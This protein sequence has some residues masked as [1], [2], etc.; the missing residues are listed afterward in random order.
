MSSISSSKN[1]LS[2]TRAYESTDSEKY[3]TELGVNTNQGIE[4]KQPFSLFKNQARSRSFQHLDENL[5]YRPNSTSKAKQKVIQAPELI[6]QF[7]DLIDLKAK[8]LNLSFELRANEVVI[9]SLLG[10]ESAIEQFE[11]FLKELK[12]K[13]KSKKNFA[14]SRKQE[15]DLKPLIS[16]T[17]S[18]HHS[19]WAKLDQIKTKIEQ[20]G[21]TYDV[22]DEKISVSGPQ[23]SVLE[24]VTWIYEFTL[25]YLEDQNNSKL[26]PSENDICES[27]ISASPFHRMQREAIENKAKELQLTCD[28]AYDLI[29]VSGRCYDV[30]E[31][32]SYL[33]EVEA[34]CKKL[35]YPKFWDFKDFDHYSEIIVENSSEEFAM[36]ADLFYKTMQDFNI[37]KLVRIQNKYLMEN[38]I[39]MIQKRKE[40]YPDHEANRK[41]LFHGTRHSS[42]RLI[43]QSS[44]TGFD[45]QFA[46]TGAYGR[47]LYFAVNADYSHNGFCHEIA[48]NK[49]QMLLTDVFIGKSFKS[50]PNGT[51]RKAPE[52]YDSVETEE[53]FYVIYNNFH[54]Y[55]LYLIEYESKF[56]ETQDD[57]D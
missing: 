52:G 13:K 43:Y 45:L 21:L 26:Q 31:F 56:P 34:T 20:L 33:H 44:D 2:I 25:S 8:D 18:F 23:E 38:Y 30:K 48:E 11:E 32:K 27:E 49:W 19:T 7:R 22:L 51:F 54:S 29:S 53:E 41:L 12:P 35:L 39:T 40:R 9:S 4:S 17:L 55:P 36:V 28:F 16:K 3:L 14:I 47:G 10:Q 37:T 24:F 46:N 1:L 42:P 6:S 15:A 50:K 57:S 5:K